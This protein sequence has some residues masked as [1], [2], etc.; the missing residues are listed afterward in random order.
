M[1]VVGNLA[2]RTWLFQQLADVDGVLRRGSH[3]VPATGDSG[4]P[5]SNAI[6]AQA[7]AEVEMN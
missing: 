7:V 1:R 6:V 2:S 3:G 5:S 4:S